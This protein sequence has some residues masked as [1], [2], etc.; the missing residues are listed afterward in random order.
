MKTVKQVMDERN[1]EM[2]PESQYLS[3]DEVINKEITILG[4]TVKQSQFGDKPYII[5]DVD[6]D[7]EPVNIATSAKEVVFCITACKGNFPLK[8]KFGREGKK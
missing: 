3:I 1:I 4:Y 8:T 2:P 6:V 7:G 5:M